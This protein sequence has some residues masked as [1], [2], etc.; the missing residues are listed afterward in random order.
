[1]LHGC[2]TRSNVNKEKFKRMKNLKLTLVALVALTL[3]GCGNDQTEYPTHGPEKVDGVFDFAGGDIDTDGVEEVVVE[4]TIEVI[5]QEEEE[6]VTFT[7][8]TFFQSEYGYW[9]ENASIPDGPFYDSNYDPN[10][11]VCSTNSSI[12]LGSLLEI[13]F[14]DSERQVRTVKVVVTENDV[15]ID[16]NIGIIMER[17]TFAELFRHYDNGYVP[18]NFARMSY[19]ILEILK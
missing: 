16:E 14:E 1:M 15:L 5:E 11:L 3:V 7:D 17:E 4:D 6:I 2:F 8:V 13:S 9:S 18:T 10:L 12:P 19:T